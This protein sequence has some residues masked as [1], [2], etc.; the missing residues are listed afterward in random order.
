MS[1]RAPLPPVMGV[2]IGLLLVACA[3]APTSTAVASPALTSSSGV[4][5]SSPL[6]TSSPAASPSPSARPTPSP[7]SQP[8]GFSCSPAAARPVSFTRSSPLADARDPLAG[9]GP[10]S[11][12][13]SGYQDLEGAL[14]LPW[15]GVLVF[16]D[17]KANTLYQLG[18]S[19]SVSV[20][21]TAVQTP[22]GLALGPSGRLLIGNG[23]QVVRLGPGA[24][25]E[26]LAT[27]QKI[28]RP[29]APNGVAVRS[30]GTALVTSSP[31]TG[32]EAVFRI[33]P[34]GTTAILWETDHVGP[35]FPNGIAL[36]PDGSTLYVGYFREQ[37]VR[38]FSL[39]PDGS[40]A[41]AR[42]LAQTGPQ[43]DGLTVDRAGNLFVATGQ[44]VQAFA[45]NGTL[46]GTIAVP[47]PAFKLTFGGSEGTTL[48]I[49]TAAT[50]YRVH[51]TIPG[52]IGG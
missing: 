22:F 4:S 44:G 2:V 52:A 47:Q 31:S 25:P 49:T 13:A 21:R 36:A 40:A 1:R 45:P 34:N 8:A 28:G 20:C 12:V 33:A 16:A 43:T 11:S 50:L 48:Y 3:P 7:T 32:E 10:V 14:W 35:H 27:S 42:V 39:G 29:I 9:A 5:S 41:T 15:D 26:V 17:R 23:S 46:W 30:D 18:P 19:A 38:A 37:V 6:P 51:L 24:A